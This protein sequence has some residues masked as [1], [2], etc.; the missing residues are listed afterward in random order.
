MSKTC[1]GLF[2]VC[3]I[4]VYDFLSLI[5][6]RWIFICVLLNKTQIKISMDNHVWVETNL[7][8]YVMETLEGITFD[9]NYKYIKY[10]EIPEKL[11]LINIHSN[12]RSPDLYQCGE[13]GDLYAWNIDDW[14]LYESDEE[15]VVTKSIE[16]FYMISDHR[17][18]LKYL[19]PFPFFTSLGMCMKIN[20]YMYYEENIFFELN[21]VE[22]L[23]LGPIKVW[24]PF[25]DVLEEGTF[26]NIINNKTYH[27]ISRLWNF[28]Q[29]N[30]GDI[31]NFVALYTDGDSIGLS[32]TN[33]NK[34]RT[35][36]EEHC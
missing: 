20:G 21:L 18:K 8:G 1:C 7:D 23:H 15:K 9:W 28:A 22:G 33:H 34:K 19:P 11:T 35:R 3:F 31:E 2:L 36:D 26:R 14:K 30:G 17:N 6:H 10:K 32:D 29:P 24:T 12:K 5:P 4:L 25:T 27:N 13:R 16:S